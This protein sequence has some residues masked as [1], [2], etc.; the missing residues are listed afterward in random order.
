[1]SS[2]TKATAMAYGTICAFMLIHCQRLPAT[3]APTFLE[4]LTN[5][6]Q[7]IDNILFLDQVLPSAACVATKWPQNESDEPFPI[8]E[9]TKLL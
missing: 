6:S 1:T 3:I 4:A 9:D 8:N 2:K 5:G 7:S